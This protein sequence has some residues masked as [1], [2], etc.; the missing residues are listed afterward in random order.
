MRKARVHWSV[1][2]LTVGLLLISLLLLSPLRD[3]VH[4]AGFSASPE[5]PPKGGVASPSARSVPVLLYHNLAPASSGL[6][7]TNAMTV[8]VEA[9]RAQMKYLADQKYHTPTLPELLAY[10][11]GDTALPERSVVI[12]FDDGYESNWEYA[13]PS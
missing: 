5:P 3:D 4:S 1:V 13:F 6:H 12:T 11:S 2:A 8:T 7:R 10:L 9:F